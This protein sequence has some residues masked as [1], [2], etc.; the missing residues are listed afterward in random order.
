MPTVLVIEDET[1]IR[2]NLLRIL[3]HEGFEAIGAA[4]GVAGLAQAKQH[5]PAL[6]LCDIRMPLLDGHEVLLA[7]RQDPTTAQIPFVFLS[8]RSERAEVRQGMN[9]GADDYL[10]KPLTRRELLDT[11]AARL[12]RQ[13]QLPD[14]VEPPAT[15]ATRDSAVELG[16]GQDPLTGLPDRAQ[17]KQRL[18]TALAHAAQYHHTV[19]LL[20]LNVCRLRSINTAYGYSLGDSLLQAVAQ[21]LLQFVGRS[22]LVARLSGDEFGIILEGLC[23]EQ[24]ALEL[25]DRIV[26]ALIAPF[27][28]Q[29][30]EIRMQASIGISLSTPQGATP[31]Q[32]MIQAEA[33]RHYCR[34]IG[35]EAYVF[36]DAS[37]ADM[38]G[39]QRVIEL[40]L[41]RAIEQEE[42]QVYYQPQVN[43][44]TGQVT[45]VEA[46]LRWNHA[47]RGMVSPETFIVMAEELGLILPIGEWVLRTACAQA[48]QWQAY[49]PLKMS[50]N[51]SSRQ[52][53]Q[54]HLVELVTRILQ[55]TELHPQ[56]LSL[57]LTETSLMA[58][59]SIAAQTLNELRDLGVTIAIDDF[60]KGY[61]SLQ[62]LSY[63]P[64][65]VLKIDQSFI[66]KITI[67][68]N[69]A[70]ISNAIITMAHSLDLQT[71]AEG[72]E[73]QAQV[74]FL[75]QSGCFTV[76]GHFYSQALSAADLERFLG[77][78]AAQNP[79]SAIA[80]VV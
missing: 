22:G 20:C 55:E 74:D 8:G 28:L 23:W 50:V 27:Y 24:E 65:D 54:P 59:L 34:Q 15:I 10:I 4:D 12:Q 7:L 30:Q 61:S 29:D 79:R 1:S 33:A 56:Q 26:D 60:G 19:A 44:L 42:L 68:D 78:G 71:V 37:L 5:L 64:I 58:D 31:E 66:R 49:G 25:V 80:S 35:R 69:A 43:L 39:D 75:R 51:L 77:R 57:E 40:D 18:R 62:Y 48:K 63:L 13:A 53:Q 76:Q 6:I 41:G 14:P 9:L 3:T 52:L 11:I 2:R 70:T 16:R 72:V 73:T 45:G 36:Y 46:L 47:Q 17:L 21:R 67:D 38:S 32:L